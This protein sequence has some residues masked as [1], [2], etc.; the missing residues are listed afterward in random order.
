MKYIQTHSTGS[1]ETAPYDVVD[2]QQDIEAFIAEVL[3]RKDDWGRITSNE[4]YS[5]EYNQGE[6][7]APIP[8]E[9]KGREI[10]KVQGFGG[11]FRMDYYLTFEMK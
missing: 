8:Q 11:W 5:V 4:G 9:W 3:S 2:F 1:D 10:K 7:L 6:L